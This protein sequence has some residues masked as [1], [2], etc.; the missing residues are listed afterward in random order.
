MAT[1]NALGIHHLARGTSSLTTDG[2]QLLKNTLL[3]VCL[4]NVSRHR[5]D[6]K[7]Q[8]EEHHG[9]QKTVDFCRDVLLIYTLTKK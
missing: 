4:P 1:P 6:R 7:M 9:Q 8:C 5:G 3:R 2:I